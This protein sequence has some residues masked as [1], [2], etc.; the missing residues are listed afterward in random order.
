MRMIILA[1]KIPVIHYVRELL[2]LGHIRHAVL[3]LQ[4]LTRFWFESGIEK[5]RRSRRTLDG[6]GRRINAE[7]GDG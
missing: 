1:F 4:R 6:F 3:T 2:D 7:T 5:I